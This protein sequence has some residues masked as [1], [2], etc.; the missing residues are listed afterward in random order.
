MLELF[1][2]SNLGFLAVDIGLAH[3]FNGFAEWAEWIPV[4]FCV[5]SALLL[6]PGAILNRFLGPVGVW[7]GYVVGALSISVGVSGMLLHLESQFFDRFTLE[8]LVYTA[9]F[10]APLALVGLGLLLIANRMEGPG[11]PRW[12]PWVVF[13]AL[14]GFA[15]NVALALCDH[16]QNGFFA[17][18]EWISV[19]A[20][21]FATSFLFVAVLRSSDRAFLRLCLVVMGVQALVGVVGFVLHLLANLRSG[22]PTLLEK[23]VFGAPAFAPLLFVDLA[24][25]A[26]LGLVEMQKAVPAPFGTASVREAQDA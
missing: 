14:G 2:T 19:I 12:A 5:A 23:L 18:A 10:A 4:Y 16:A 13:L 3:A 20:G 17:P 26:A 9:P 11:S 1:V 22:E 25:L 7:I 8:S 15:G 24:A 21:A 6:V